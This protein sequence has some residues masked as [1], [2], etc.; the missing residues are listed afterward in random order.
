M[1][2]CS[3]AL[4]GALLVGYSA[5]AAAEC[6][7]PNAL[8]NGEVADATEVR[9]NFEAIARCAD[10]LADA[11]V[12]TTG[13]PATGE[14]A[15]FSGDKTVTGA[16][17]TGDVTT[18]GG[19]TTTLAST[20]VT[21]GSYTNANITVDAEGRISVAANGSTGSGGAGFRGA[22]VYR[23]GSLAGQNFSSGA[24]LP[25]DAENYD[26]N[27]FHDVSANTSRIAIPADTS[28]VI[29]RGEAFLSDVAAGTDT[30]MSSRL[31]GSG[32]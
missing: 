26:T 15:V 30:D 31:T 24:T 7:V 16:D 17:L 4:I 3:A 2:R 14:I 19:T 23:N 22:L 12:T 32:S 10:D 8:T 25:F 13:T 20:G 21:A 9:G 1:I 29:L 6:T 27:G 28:K 11:A 18:S 5:P